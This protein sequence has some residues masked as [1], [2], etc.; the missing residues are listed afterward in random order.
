MKI[1][2]E[3]HMLMTALMGSHNDVEGI[4][5]VGEK[6]ALQIVTTPA[7]LRTYR[8]KYAE[9]IERNLALIKLPHADFPY[10]ECIPVHD[11]FKPR[12]LYRSLG[13]YDIDVTGSMVNA[14]EQLKGTR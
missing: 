11:E 7:R 2:P 3:Q 6:T 1:T 12:D 8:E 13:R 9:L 10:S 5:R 14:F 4:H